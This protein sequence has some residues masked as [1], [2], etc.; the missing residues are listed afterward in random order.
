MPQHNAM[1]GGMAK[2]LKITL[3]TLG[4]ACL[5]ACASEDTTFGPDD[6]SPGE[7]S[8]INDAAEML[9]MPR[10]QSPPQFAPPYSI[11]DTAPDPAQ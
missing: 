9:D 2:Y 1:S 4:S 7:T 3:V 10:D 5:C 8:A 11:G 6:A